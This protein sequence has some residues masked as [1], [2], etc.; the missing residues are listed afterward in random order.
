MNASLILRVTLPVIQWDLHLIEQKTNPTMRTLGDRMNHWTN[1]CCQNV[2]LSSENQTH[3]LLKV[4]Q[5]IVE[6]LIPFM[7][8]GNI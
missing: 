5:V 3:Q 1:I 4:D 2:N 6:G 7:D 8:E